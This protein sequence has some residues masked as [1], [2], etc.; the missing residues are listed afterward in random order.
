MERL[1]R[2]KKPTE[3]KALF[4]E[5]F[6]F[7]ESVV[8]FPVRHHS[9]AC[10]YHLRKTIAAY[11][12]EVV[13]IEG[14]ENAQSIIEDL[15]KEGNKP[16]FCIYLSYDDVKGVLGEEQ[17]KYRAYYPMLA[18]SPELNALEEAKLQGIPCEFIDLSY[19]DK[20]YNQKQNGR[21][22][23]EGQEDDR[24]FTVSN[25]YKVLTEKMN[26]KN[27]NDLWEKLFEL[28]AFNESTEQFV[29]KV[30]TYCYYSRSM[31]PD[32]EL[33]SCGDLVREEYMRQRIALA[34]KK[35]HK[36]LVVTGGIHTVALAE[37]CIAKHAESEDI[38]KREIVEV[39]KV[40]GDIP[41]TYLMPYSFEASDQNLGY[42]AG[43]AFPYFY[44]KVWE[45]QQKKKKAPYEE[46]VLSFIINVANKMRKKQA[47]S[48]T[49]EMQSF[50]MAQGL[51]DLREKPSCGVFELIDAVQS[52]FVKGQVNTHYEPV[53]DE[54]FKLLTGMEMGSVTNTQTNPPI[55]LDFLEKC[56][57]FKIS[58]QTTIGKETKLNVANKQEHRE[59]SYFFN[60]M[61]YL[62]T[63]FC[64]YQ[65]G[66]DE[67]TG[68]GRILLNETWKYRYTPKVQANL[69]DQ[70][71]YGGTV[72]Q[73]C[74]Y[75]LTKQLKTDH[76]TAASLSEHFL[77]AEKM[78][79][80]ELY[81][82]MQ[83][84]LNNVLG[85]DM[86]FMS[87][88]VCFENLTKILDCMKLRQETINQDLENLR[89]YA[90]HRMR[91][92][93]PTMQKVSRDQ[94]DLL[95]DKLKFVY[96]CFVEERKDTLE[97][98]EDSLKIRE[99]LDVL[100][101]TFEDNEANSALVGT[102]SGILLRSDALTLEIIMDK[103]AWYLQGSQ[104]AKKQSAAFLKGFFKIAKDTAFIEPR[105]LKLIDQILREVEGDEFLEI[106]P[107][108]RLAFTY[109]LPF[110][111]DKIARQVCKLYGVKSDAILVEEAIDP[112]I[113]TYAKEVEVARQS[114]MLEWF[115]KGELSNGRTT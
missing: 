26:C 42:E 115:K 91:V 73:A 51:A 19:H 14:P 59:K 39:R 61:D 8:L 28:P 58:T 64:E 74:L 105:L 49:D 23:E 17:G 79:I 6:D 102:C 21:L 104:K 84:Y 85:D 63:G 99:W 43:M 88:A 101:E 113:I 25:Y 106:L 50:Y 22:L 100:K 38:E 76:Q 37:S 53:L 72:R 35:Y 32:Q 7:N 11:K 55:V 103:L 92:L 47:L 65:K 110:E 44:Q 98:R 36:I 12:P 83:V 69:V 71:V 56:K 20:L 95:C 82:E 27:F 109:F 67:R 10:A 80:R 16:P 29:E 52:S 46:A 86:D 45:L 70:C 96:E 48:I 31:T 54:L 97:D 112:Q 81:H 13:L 15:T 3:I 87:V 114:E 18:Y 24:L 75:L 78:G 68:V 77:R 33:T 4:N 111:I 89:A 9:P 60:Q 107:D 41:P 5:S 93:M 90:L 57:T 34:Q 30:F 94:E 1:L 2:G 108:L 66:Q 62:D 40:P